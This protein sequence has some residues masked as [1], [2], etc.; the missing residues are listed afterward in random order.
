[1]A[2]G[3]GPICC[4]EMAV[5]TYHLTPCNV[6]EEGKLQTLFRLQDVGLV[7]CRSVREQGIQVEYS[8]GNC[9][10]VCHHYGLLL[11]VVLSPLG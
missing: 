3:N 10:E 8:P 9:S 5:T 4:P 1:M 6:P 11:E 7:F 2:L